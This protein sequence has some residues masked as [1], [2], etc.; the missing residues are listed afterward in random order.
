MR[1]VNVFLKVLE[2][3]G[4]PESLRRMFIDVGGGG[5]EREIAPKISGVR[6]FQ[7]KN[8][9]QTSSNLPESWVLFLF[10]SE[11]KTCPP[12]LKCVHSIPT[13]TCG[14]YVTA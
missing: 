14:W 11:V 9:E 1:W 4:W 6:V 5:L 3:Q 8:A 12:P 13:R 7:A 2:C 10:R